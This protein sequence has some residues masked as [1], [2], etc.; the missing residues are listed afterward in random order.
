KETDPD[1]LQDIYRQ[2]Q[3]MELKDLP[4]IPLFYG[5]TWYEYSDEYWVGW[6]KE[7]FDPWFATFW[8]WPSNMPVWFYLVKKGQT[9]TKPAWIDAL[10]IP[11]SKIFGDLGVVIKPP[12]T[13]TATI[14]TTV[15]TATTVVTTVE[16]TTTIEKTSL[17]T[18]ER[19]TTVEKEIP[20]M[21]PIS[22]AGAAIVALIIGLVVGRV[23]KKEK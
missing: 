3:E 2:L 18:V 16:K 7:E 22:I 8:Q 20:T 10:K 21:E 23:T 1:K 19:P 13:T 14:S 15:A 5:A 17:S 6:P 12:V 11:T 4:A 9:P